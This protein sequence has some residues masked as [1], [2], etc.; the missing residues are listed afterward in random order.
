M[1]QQPP[2]LL[3]PFE[4][5][6]IYLYSIGEDRLY[7]YKVQFP[8]KYVTNNTY[9]AFSHGWL[10]KY[11]K[12]VKLVNPFTGKIIKIHCFGKMPR[13]R[14][15]KVILSRNPTLCSGDDDGFFLGGIWNRHTVSLISPDN[16]VDVIFHKEMLYGLVEG[17]RVI[18]VDYK[19]YCGD[20]H[21]DGGIAPII[22]IVLAHQLPTRSPGPYL[23]EASNGNLLLVH[24]FAH[25]LQKSHFYKL[26]AEK[27]TINVDSNGEEVFSWEEIEESENQDA[28]FV[29]CKRI[30]S[31]CVPHCS[32]NSRFSIYFPVKY[33]EKFW[34]CFANGSKIDKATGDFECGSP[35]LEWISNF[36]LIQAGN[37]DME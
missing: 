13:G 21:E 37:N 29:C 6:S 3:I 15:G 14:F 24:Q 25:Q 31:T 19:K 10:L 7:N 26:V 4:P 16:I 18:A 36:M 17:N 30:S 9:R 12:N 32:Q 23:V 20:C 2:M 34:V 33:R 8:L 35:A 27:N 5:D 11:R 28:I 1:H 22:E